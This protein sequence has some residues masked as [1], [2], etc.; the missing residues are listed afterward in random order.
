MEAAEKQVGTQAVITN[1]QRYS[2]HDGPGLRT[3]IFLKG[4]PLRCLWCSNP[5]TQKAHPELLYAPTRCIA[6]GACAEVCPTKAFTQD[7]ARIVFDREL[8]TNCG[9]CAVECPTGAASMTGYPI[10]IE[11]ALD[12][13]E[14]DI[15]FFRNSGGGV[16][17]SGGE[18]A[19]YPDF[20]ARLLVGLKERSIHSA[21]ET[22]GF[23]PW[24]VLWKSVEAADLVLYDLKAI[25]PELHLSLT[26]V[27]NTSILQNARNLAG[28][29]E[30][31]FR[32]PVVPG[33]TGTES[34]LTEIAKF[35]SSIKEGLK[36]HLIPYH[37]FGSG[38][39]SSLGLQYLLEEV[40]PPSQ[41]QMQEYGNIVSAFGLQVK[42]YDP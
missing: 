34:N 29:K 21:V 16:T 26:G 31:V 27:D 11:E 8:C 18:P 23:P 12:T 13:L 37:S 2:L 25:D 3:I 42:A 1:I 4:C 28:K 20:C 40:S 32:V 39:Y 14:A 15:V 41:E 6:C 35:I 19:L 30:V 5:E 22:C 33:Y 36:V 24:E 10:T 17:I 9:L 7:E 38:K